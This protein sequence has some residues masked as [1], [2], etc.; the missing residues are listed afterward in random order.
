MD[1][2]ENTSKSNPYLFWQKWKSTDKPKVMEIPMQIIDT[3]DTIVYD[4]S[5]V[6]DKWQKDFKDLYNPVKLY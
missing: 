6:F 5:V 2:L 3:H 4:E 1:K